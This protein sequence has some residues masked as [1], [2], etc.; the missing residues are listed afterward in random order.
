MGTTI[1]CFI[2]KERE[3]SIEEIEKQ[4]EEVFIKFKSDFEH[5]ERYGQFTS[6][7]NGKWLFN[8]VPKCDKYPEHTIGEGNGFFLTVYENI[9]NL[10]SAERFSSLSFK[11]RIISEQLFK[12]LNAYCDVFR[13]SA[14]LLIGAGG[15]G[16]TDRITDMSMIDGATF[17]QICEKMKELNGEPGI[18]LDELNDKSWFLRR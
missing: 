18:S 15:F 13:S 6:K 14:E 12:I 2:P 4:F 3:L 5:L 9:I 11:E 8:H 1:D 17:D 7:V 16:E 10:G